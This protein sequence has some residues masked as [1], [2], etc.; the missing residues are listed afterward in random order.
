MQGTQVVTSFY[1]DRTEASR[2]FTRRFRAATG[3]DAPP[4]QMQAGVYS[5]VL[6]YLRAVE[7]AGT[8]EPMA[9]S[10]KLRELP[11]NDSLWEGA[12]VREDG[13]VMKDMFLAQVKT[14]EESK[15]P[16]DY[17]KNLERLP[18]NDII[19]PMS[20]DCKIAAEK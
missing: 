16:W 15:Y 5:S 17:Y 10:K 19:K 1:W 20:L 6:A 9:V 14:P 13:R 3:K 18:A 8:D 4:S 2:E 7:A 12:R 11:V